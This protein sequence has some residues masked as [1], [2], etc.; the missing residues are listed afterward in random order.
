[1]QTK[2]IS[3]KPNT[4]FSTMKNINSRAMYN[5]PLFHIKMHLNVINLRLAAV[6]SHNDRHF[7]LYNIKFPLKTLHKKDL[8]Q[9]NFNVTK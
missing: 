5:A 3:L 7:F 2:V 8:L 4:D 6:D 9:L 1:M